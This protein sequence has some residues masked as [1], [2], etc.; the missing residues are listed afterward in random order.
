[1]RLFQAVT[2]SSR[3]SK[4]EMMVYEMLAHHNWTRPMFM[5]TTLGQDNEANLSGYLQLEGL[6]RR[7]TPFRQPDGACDADRMYDNMMNRFK[8]GNL[9][10]PGLYLD[11]TTLRMCFT[12]R[13]MFV[14]LAKQLLK[15]GKRDKAL[16]ALQK[17][18][19]EIPAYNVRYE[20]SSVGYDY[21][22]GL[23]DMPESFH[24]LGHDKES[25]RILLSIAKNAAQYL[26][27]YN[28]LSWSQLSS[29]GLNCERRYIFLSSAV[30][31]LHRCNSKQAARYDAVLAKLEQTPVG[32]LLAQRLQQ[33]SA[34]G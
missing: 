19:K 23:F 34:E 27:W 17:C 22:T 28:T 9:S 4:S 20:F 25:E 11:E 18:E 29:Y 7:I 16:K 8:Y 31:G 2:I 1:M 32:Q 13:A 14:T 12:H 15:E 26:D 5:S 10:Q 3:V 33:R 21:A 30:E 24:Q 6:A